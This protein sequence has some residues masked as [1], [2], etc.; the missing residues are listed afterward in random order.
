[1]YGERFDIPTPDK[2]IFISWFQG[3]EVFRSGCCWERGH[4]R[5]FYF[6]PGHETFPIYYD[7]NVIQVLTNAVRLARPRVMIPDS[8]PNAKDS[9]EPLPAHK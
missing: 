6:R 7:K 4:G 2:L 1:M 9:P 8:C 5:V 3:G